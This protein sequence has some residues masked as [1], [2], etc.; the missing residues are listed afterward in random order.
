[1]T[2]RRRAAGELEGEV[3]AALWRAGRPMTSGEVRAAL[4]PSPALTTVLTVLDRLVSKGEV[5]RVGVS[6][7]GVRFAPRHTESEHRGDEMRSVLAVASDRE[8]TLL[9]FAAALDEEDLA[10]LRRAVDGRPRG[11]PPR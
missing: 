3:L 2:V 6:T 5:D 1:M 8:A 11:G 10:I 9:S 7:R 4:D